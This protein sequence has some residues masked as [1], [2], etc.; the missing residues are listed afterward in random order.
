[1]RAELPPIEATPALPEDRDYWY[2]RDA[3]NVAGPF[4]RAQVMDRW[5]RG[6]LE[7]YH[8]VSQDQL[9]WVSVSTLRNTDLVASKDDSL[10]S[11]AIRWRPPLRRVS[12]SVL[13][14]ALL[15]GLGWVLHGVTRGKPEATA[16]ILSVIK[17]DEEISKATFGLMGSKE[18]PWLYAKA[19]YTYVHKMQS[20]DMSGCPAVFRV[21]FKHHLDCWIK[22]GEAIKSIPEDEKEGFAIGFLN[23]YINGEKD[24]GL[25]SMTTGV[26]YAAIDVR[27]S[28]EEVKQIAAHY[29]VAPP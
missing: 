19:I 23:S 25:F 27:T 28:F 11:I 12:A 20:V 17:K 13:G 9:I 8:E 14:V 26:R 7:W 5:G 15:V 4:T 29:G 24:G 10:K 3:G 1:M 21:A 2:V 22:L 18:T 6:E 16:A